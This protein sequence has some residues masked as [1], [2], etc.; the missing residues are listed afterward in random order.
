MFRNDIHIEFT[1]RNLEHLLHINPN[2]ESIKEQIMQSKTTLVQELGIPEIPKDGIFVSRGTDKVDTFL[3]G[4]LVC[5]KELSFIVS[6]ETFDCKFNDTLK[7][8]NYLGVDEIS[9]INAFKILSKERLIQRKVEFIEELYKLFT[10]LSPNILRRLV[11]IIG[12]FDELQI[13][14]GIAIIADHFI[15]GALAQ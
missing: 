6:L 12:V 11:C 8:V 15:L 7:T 13:Y 9:L 10:P 1:V 3:S 2:C 4:I 5:L 14:E